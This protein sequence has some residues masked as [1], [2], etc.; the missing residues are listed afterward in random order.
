MSDH[1]PTSSPQSRE[2]D[3]IQLSPETVEPKA[4]KRGWV[5]GVVIVGLVVLVAVGA[6]AAYRNLVGEPFAAAGAVPPDADVV[7]SFDLLQVRDTDRINRLASAFAEPLADAG[8][9]ESADVNLLEQIDEELSAEFGLTLTDDVIPWIG[10]S[11]SLAVWVPADLDGVDPDV[12]LA[13]AVRDGSGAEAFIEKVVD[14]ATIDFG[15][16]VERSQVRG[17]DRWIVTE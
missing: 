9:I 5:I 3:P 15:G 14:Q 2:P 16:S 13:M 4:S 6:V 12:L 10:R 11:V 7:I 17:G 8:E 1:D